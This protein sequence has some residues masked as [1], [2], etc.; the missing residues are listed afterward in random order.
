[1][2]SNTTCLIYPQSSPP[3]ASRRF[4]A[5]FLSAPVML[6]SCSKSSEFAIPIS[7]SV[8]SVKHYFS[9]ILRIGNTVIFCILIITRPEKSLCILSHQTLL[10]LRLNENSFSSVV[11]FLRKYLA[12]APSLSA[13]QK[14][15]S[16]AAST[17]VTSSGQISPEIL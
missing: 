17:L 7:K 6:M 14:P 2:L 8:K 12:I 15:F 5:T 3:Q 9:Y 11:L 16:S 13:R 4:C 1:M 10:I